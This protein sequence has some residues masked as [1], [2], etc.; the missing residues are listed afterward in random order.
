MGRGGDH[1]AAVNNTSFL[2]HGN[3]AKDGTRKATDLELKRERL[4]PSLR[5]SRSVARSGRENVNM[6]LESDRQIQIGPIGSIDRGRPCLQWR[7]VVTSFLTE[8][9]NGTPFLPLENSNNWNDLRPTRP[10]ARSG[11]GTHSL[12]HVTFLLPLVVPCPSFR[13]NPSVRCSLSLGSAVSR[14]PWKGL[15]FAPPVLPL[16]PVLIISAS[17]LRAASFLPSIP[18]RPYFFPSQLS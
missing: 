11:T 4:F 6:G 17:D 18:S 3:L 8:W 5:R 12:T 1:V 13:N 9:E 16:P 14:V 10:S 2:H 15:R 7:R